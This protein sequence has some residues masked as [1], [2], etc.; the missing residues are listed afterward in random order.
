MLLYESNVNVLVCNLL[1]V[2]GYHI[3]QQLSTTEQGENIIAIRR[4][5]NMRLSIEA[6]GQISSK[7]RKQ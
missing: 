4:E 6:K 2:K 1:A 3:V 7:K 5:D